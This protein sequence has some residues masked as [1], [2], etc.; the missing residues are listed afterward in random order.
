LQL[1][2]IFE[3]GAVSNGDIFRQIQQLAAG[4]R[5][6]EVLAGDVRQLMG[7]VEDHHFRFGISSANRSL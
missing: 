7:F 4:E 3:F 2:G 6:A 1:L 5:L